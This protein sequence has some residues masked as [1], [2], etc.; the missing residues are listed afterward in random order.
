M[1]C[2][3]SDCS[4]CHA[5]ASVCPKHCIAMVADEEGVLYPEIDKNL[6]INCGRCNDVCPIYKKRKIEDQS[7]AYLFI[8]SDDS[9]CRKSSSGVGV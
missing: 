8:N 7:S 9:V 4:G 6:C 5:C 2:K 1:I 3:K